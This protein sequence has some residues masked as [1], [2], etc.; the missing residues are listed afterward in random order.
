MTSNE[1][2]LVDALESDMQ[3]WEVVVGH[4]EHGIIDLQTIDGIKMTGAGYAAMLRKRVA[5]HK[6][7]IEKIKKG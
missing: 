5:E 2:A 7:L 1:K 3:I 6:D 4:Y